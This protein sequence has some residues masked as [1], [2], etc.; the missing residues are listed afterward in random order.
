MAQTQSK[1]NWFVIGISA[2]VVVV[3]IALGA[4]VVWMNYR[5]TDAGPAPS[6]SK[7]FNA[8]TGAISFGDGKD[9]VDIFVDF[10][11]PVCNSFEQQFGPELEKAAES[12]KI[13]LNYHPIAIL[14][15][16]S[17]GTEYSSRSAAAAVCVAS[18]QPDK[19]LA[20]AKLLF[21]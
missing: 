10:Q 6:S 13:T 17:Q 19:Y 20:Y 12:G 4:V 7:S 11:C 18:E 1:P 3:L 16:Y 2:A 9:T 14:D 21:A 5:A 15:R 8:D